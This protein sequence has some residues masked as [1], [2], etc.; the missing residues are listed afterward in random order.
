[1]LQEDAARELAVDLCRAWPRSVPDMAAKTYLAL[2]R[3][4]NK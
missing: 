1:V 4:N 3:A 2:L